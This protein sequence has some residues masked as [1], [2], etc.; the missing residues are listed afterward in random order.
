MF[1]GLITYLLA[2]SPQKKGS[3]RAIFPE[4]GRVRGPHSENSP[5]RRFEHPL[6]GIE[7]AVADLLHVGVFGA[8][9]APFDDFLTRLA[10][11]RG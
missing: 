10:A 8:W 5:H 7:Y 3:A 1:N 2:I 4:K 9:F 11:V 6:P